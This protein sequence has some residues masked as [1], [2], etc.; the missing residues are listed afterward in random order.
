MKRATLIGSANSASGQVQLKAASAGPQAQ[1]LIVWFTRL[2]PD[3]GR[4][5]AS[6]SEIA[7]N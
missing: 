1:Y 2:A 6:I 3:S 7:L 4:F 5:R